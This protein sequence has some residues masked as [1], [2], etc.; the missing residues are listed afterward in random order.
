MGEA[1]S[2][3]RPVDVCPAERARHGWRALAFERSRKAQR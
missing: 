2:G 3:K 1:E